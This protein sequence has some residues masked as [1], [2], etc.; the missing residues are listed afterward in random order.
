MT[1]QFWREKHSLIFSVTS[2]RLLPF[3]EAPPENDFILVISGMDLEVEIHDYLHFF[4][5]IWCKMVEKQSRNF[6]ENAMN[7]HDTTEVV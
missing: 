6:V 2:S 7:V 1:I 4:H 3:R 5:S